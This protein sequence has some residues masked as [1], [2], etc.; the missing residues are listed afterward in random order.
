MAT[1]KFTKD[2]R[3]LR[4]R[5]HLAIQ[6][7]Y[8]NNSYGGPT[9]SAPPTR[10]VP[11]FSTGRPM[12]TRAPLSAAETDIAQRLGISTDEY[13]KQ[14]EKMEKLKAAGVIQDGR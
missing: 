13:Q 5:Q 7:P 8:G 4:Q 9:V 6:R 10:N 11:S 12:N 1:D 14:K 2:R 3:C